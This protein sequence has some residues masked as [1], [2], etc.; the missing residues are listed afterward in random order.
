MQPP[1]GLEPGDAIGPYRLLRQLG[2]GGMGQVWAAARED[3]EVYALKILIGESFTSEKAILFNDEV[4]AASVLDHDSIVPTVDFGC[5]GTI[6]WLAMRM[7]HGASLKDLLDILRPQRRPLAPLVVAY[8]GVRIS[9][10]LHYAHANA[11][12]EGRL[13]NL[14]HRDVSPHNVLLDREGGIYLTDFG[15]ARTSVQLHATTAGTVRGKPSYMAPEQVTG[16]SVDHRT[17]IFALG[18]VLYEAASTHLLFDGK[19]P[20]DKMK[21]VLHVQPKPLPLI[22]PRFPP[23]L[24]K[25]IEQCLAKDPAGRWTTAARLNQRLVALVL[26]NGGMEKARHLLAGVMERYYPETTER[27]NAFSRNASHDTDPTHREL[28]APT[29]TS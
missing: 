6:H 14:V 24:W 20:V 5:D 12:L 17:D 28:R 15:V 4:R 13:L 23:P 7:V 19:R 3:Q 18:S 21:A 9:S 27:G 22:V 8:L 29:V 25:V 1:R 2:E 16:R 10:A 26:A 11:Q